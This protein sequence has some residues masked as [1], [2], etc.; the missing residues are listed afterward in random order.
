MLGNGD[1]HSAV[2]MMGRELDM[3]LGMGWVLD[4]V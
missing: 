4:S 3:G 2:H 1:G